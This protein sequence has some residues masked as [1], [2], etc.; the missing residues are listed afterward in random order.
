MKCTRPR[1]VRVPVFGQYT[2]DAK[3]LWSYMFVD[4][5]KCL[6]CKCNLSRQW[7]LRLTHEAQLAST[8]HFITLTY[9]EEHYPPGG[10]VSKEDVQHFISDLR[11]ACGAGIRYFIGSE[12]GADQYQNRPHYHGLI[13]NA[14][15]SLWSTPCSGSDRVETRRGKNNSISYVNTAYNDIWKRGF[16]TV[17]LF[18]PK[19]AGYLAHYY[20]DKIDAP[21]GRTENFSLMSKR[22]GIGSQYADSISDKL[23]A[24]LPLLS[25]S[26][27][28]VPQP[29]YYKTRMQRLTGYCRPYDI[30]QINESKQI[31]GDLARVAEIS[32]E[33][34]LSWK[35]L[36]KSL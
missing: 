8:T 27:T 28:P 6:A 20:V 12:Y 4:C 1:K 26:G 3:Q 9:D 36:P 22:P 35:H 31:K 2:P 7:T 34:K 10:N 33:Q 25:R 17:G 32:L 21:A 15:D 19:R 30:E 13:F 23:I 16:V 5:G 14:P 29:R 24:G 18:H 11:K